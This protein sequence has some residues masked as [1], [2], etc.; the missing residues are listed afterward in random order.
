MH[1]KLT[2]MV[3]EAA[4]VNE[5]ITRPSFRHSLGVISLVSVYASTEESDLTKETFYATLEL[6]VHQCPR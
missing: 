6:I 4:P 1:N 5:R 2:P 3:I